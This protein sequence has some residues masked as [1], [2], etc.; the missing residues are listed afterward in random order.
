LYKI[1]VI[2]KYY[3]KITQNDPNPTLIRFVSDEFLSFQKKTRNA[4]LIFTGYH[5]NN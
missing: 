3:G 2:S 1:L 5:L 4:Q